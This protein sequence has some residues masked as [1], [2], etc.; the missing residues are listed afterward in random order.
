MEFHLVLDTRDIIDQL[1][2][3]ASDDRER[4][5]YRRWAVVLQD[6]VSAGNDSDLAVL[7][8]V[9]IDYPKSIIAA[10]NEVLDEQLAII[11]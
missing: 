2:V 11:I 8:G 6:D 4:I 5:A 9:H 7:V 3:F 10:G 1:L